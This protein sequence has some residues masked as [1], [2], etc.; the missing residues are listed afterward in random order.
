M[1]GLVLAKT[2]YCA[3]VDVCGLVFTVHSGDSNKA[4]KASLPLSAA[5][6]CFLGYRHASFDKIRIVLEILFGLW[7]L[8]GLWFVLQSGGRANVSFVV[9]PLA[10][11]LG[12]DLIGRELKDRR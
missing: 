2:I 7:S 5:I 3:I 9:L 12:I 6:G 10:A 11:A 8:S 1:S 4:W